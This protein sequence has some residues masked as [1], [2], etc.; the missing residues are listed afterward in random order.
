MVTVR[1]AE[2]DKL[3]AFD[4]GADD[5]I[6]KPFSNEEL[7]ARVRAALRRS[8]VGLPLPKIETPDLKIDFEARTVDARCERVHLTPQGI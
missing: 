8:S 4:S 7:L 6:V 3:D 1:D 2:H 5:Y